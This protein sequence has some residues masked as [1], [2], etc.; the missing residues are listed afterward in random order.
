MFLR[1]QIKHH[2]M[3]IRMKRWS[4][5]DAKRK[6][7]ITLYSFY[8][9]NVLAFVCFFVMNELVDSSVFCAGIPFSVHLFAKAIWFILCVLFD[10]SFS[11][12]IIVIARHPFSFHM[13]RNFWNDNLNAPIA[14]FTLFGDILLLI[15]TVQKQ[16]QQQQID[17]SNLHPEIKRFLPFCFPKFKCKGLTTTTA[18]VTAT[19]AM[20]T[21]TTHRLVCPF[22]KVERIIWNA[23]IIKGNKK[24][25]Q[26]EQQQRQPFLKKMMETSYKESV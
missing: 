24:I 25:W 3:L 19:A 14:L 13:D 2:F 8:I 21:M 1:Q 20:T 18:V 11:R 7:C 9:Y 26:N 10:D 17:N 22:S 16:Q 15:F 6:L 23:N 5:E 12:S 4:L